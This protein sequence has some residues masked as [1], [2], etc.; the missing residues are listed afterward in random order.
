MAKVFISDTYLTN[1]ADAIRVKNN[2]NTTYTPAQMVTAINSLSLEQHLPVRID[3]IQSEHQTIKVI[4]TVNPITINGNTTVNLPTINLNATVVPDEGY[5]AGTLNQS[6]ANAE[7]G[8][9]VTFSATEAVEQEGIL[10]IVM[11]ASIN[12][13]FIEIEIQATAIDG[14]TNATT[15]RIVPYV[16]NNAVEVH[17]SFAM[18]NIDSLEKDET[19]SSSGHTI[20]TGTLHAVSG[21]IIKFSLINLA[22]QTEVTSAIVN[23]P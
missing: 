10:N 22:T 12:R 23:V 2:T 6:L 18:V 16:N 4:P 5:T 20:D 19:Y 21:D 17:D 13:V 7:W 9:T 1:I 14:Y 3:I 8:S 11:T 15:C